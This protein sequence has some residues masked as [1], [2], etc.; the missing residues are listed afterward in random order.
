[1]SGVIASDTTWNCPG[2]P[3]TLTGTV[4]IDE[5]VTLTIERCA[6]VIFESGAA[7]VNRGTIHS[8]GTGVNPVVFQRRN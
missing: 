7:L 3:Y 1:V 2:S 8:I 5:G 4:Q 6:E